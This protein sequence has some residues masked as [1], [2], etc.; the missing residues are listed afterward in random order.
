MKK[1]NEYNKMSTKK[2]SRILFWGMLLPLLIVTIF[3]CTFFYKVSNEILN[4][5]IKKQMEVS[6]RLELPCCRQHAAYNF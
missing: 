3:A 2:K 6:V 1:D 5:Y 4:L